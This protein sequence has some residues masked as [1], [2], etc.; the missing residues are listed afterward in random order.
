MSRSTAAACPPSQTSRSFDPAEGGSLA[1]EM[2]ESERLCKLLSL[3][4]TLFYP[5]H[6]FFFLS[7]DDC[8]MQYIDGNPWLSPI[9]EDDIV[10]EGNA[11]SL[12]HCQSLRTVIV[13]LV[14]SFVLHFTGALNG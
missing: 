13:S 14:V 11:N 12:N 4:D 8:S 3:L 10:F 7:V 9:L 1:L 6:V 2:E 5:V